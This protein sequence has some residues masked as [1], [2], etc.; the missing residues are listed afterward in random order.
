MNVPIR[1]EV[2][3]TELLT[4]PLHMELAIYQTS[5][6]SALLEWALVQ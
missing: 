4:A 2:S 6:T 5:I 3:G 1:I